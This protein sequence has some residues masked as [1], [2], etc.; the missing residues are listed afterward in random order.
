MTAQAPRA[1]AAASG[2]RSARGL[3]R[4]IRSGTRSGYRR[5]G[6]PGGPLGARGAARGDDALAAAEVARHFD[7]V[8][9]E[10]RQVLR[11]PLRLPLPHLDHQVPARAEGSARIP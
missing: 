9:A 5:P 7:R 11:E 8:V 6:A 3:P 2:A 1:S 10:A 4:S